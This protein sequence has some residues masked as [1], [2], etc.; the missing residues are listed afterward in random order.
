[1]KG[2][3]LAF[4][5]AVAAVTPAFGADLAGT[6]AC[7]LETRDGDTTRTLSEITTYSTKGRFTSNLVFVEKT[8]DGD[9][10][11][12]AVYSGRYTLRDRQLDLV[13]TRARI[14]EIRVD[15]RVA[16]TG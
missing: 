12:D 14:R 2:A 8:R 1:M 4:V 7:T 11:A 13:P 6:W 16:W 9:F 3:D 15:D 5:I 10:Q